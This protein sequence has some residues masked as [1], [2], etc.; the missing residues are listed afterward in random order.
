MAERAR[1]KDLFEASTALSQAELR[2]EK[3]RR[4]LGLIAGPLLFILL[5]LFPVAELSFE[6]A[7][8]L[9]V[10][11][12]ILT[13]WVTEAV[14]IPVTALLGPALAV[15]CGVGS[16]KTMFVSFGD[17]IIFLFLGSFIIAE[18]MFTTGLD[19]RF[20]YA[21][22]SLKWVG[23]SA[24]R[25]LIAF[26]V[27]TAGL[28]MWLSNTATTAMM[29]PIGMSILTALSR[30]MERS[31]GKTVDLTRLRYGTGLMLATAYAASIGG[32]ATPVGTPPN[33]I[34]LGLLDKLLHVNISFFQWMMLAS[35]AMI[36]MLVFLVVYMLRAM[37][38][39]MRDIAGSRQYIL[40]KRAGLGS[41]TRQEKNAMIAFAVTVSL[42][43]LPGGLTV[44][45][46][47]DSPFTHALHALLPEAVVA[48]FGAVL[49]FVLPV[50]WRKRRFTMTW[51]QAAHI[52]WGT[53]LLF[54][55]GISLGE[56]MFSTG[57]A[58]MMGHELIAVTGA[59]SLIA[60]TFLFGTV[61]LLLTEVT[62]NTAGATMV[63]PL[64]IASAQAAGVSPIPPAVVVALC[65]SMAFMLPVATPPN[66]IV[67]GSGC[68]PITKM[69]K[70]GA[71]FNLASIVLVPVLVLAMCALLGIS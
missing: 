29:F 37:P 54:G 43:V 60:L 35:P 20:A 32:I 6:A 46:G 27:I 34:V 69:I 24:S 59:S 10:L 68:V 42:W 30:L 56:A 3:G 18:A 22:L 17:P 4:T 19:K 21:I 9:A 70:H 38:P 52:D 71:L 62:S 49:L 50:D 14:P 53:L 25:I 15:V 51:N 64:A 11:A 36:L 40:E 47:A 2:F 12:W 63:C 39:E 23:S 57:L 58:D 41:W 65:A 45:V 5:N 31:T 26:V 13:W 67:Y 48:V 8:L 61:T 28:S 44:L 16:A 1:F 33:L 55:C 66:A 7:R